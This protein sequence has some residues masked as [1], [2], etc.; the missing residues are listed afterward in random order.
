MK[1]YTYRRII[2]KTQYVTICML[3]T[4]TTSLNMPKVV[5]N[6]KAIPGRYMVK[7]GRIMIELNIIVPYFE[8]M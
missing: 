7:D 6:W 4:V 1:N 8:I 2:F 3:Y 5:Y